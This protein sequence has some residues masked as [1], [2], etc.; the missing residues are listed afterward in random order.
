MLGRFLTPSGEPRTMSTILGGAASLAA[1]VL[2]LSACG[3][4]VYTPITGDPTKSGIETKPK[5]GEG[6]FCKADGQGAYPLEAIVIAR[7]AQ[8][9]D[10]SVGEGGGC[11]G[12]PLLEAWAVT[13]NRESL[14]W[15]EAD[16]L[17]FRRAPSTQVD[18]HLQTKYSAGP[19]PF[20][21]EWYMEWLHTLKDGTRPQPKRVLIVYKKTLGTGYIPHWEGAIEMT[22]IAPNVT[23]FVMY[24]GIHAAETGPDKAAGAVRDTLTRVRTLAP[25]WEF[26]RP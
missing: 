8:E 9:G 6:R 16:L 18:F 12:R 25:N 7:E 21:Q 23:S 14:H 22:E 11:I 5:P 1:A 26:L 15:S 24:N 2:L 20:T 3:S 19:S 17:S 4:S 13:H 10:I